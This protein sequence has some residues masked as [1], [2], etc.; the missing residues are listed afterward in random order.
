[1]LVLAVLATNDPLFSG[2]SASH[3]SNWVN[4]NPELGGF[5]PFEKDATVNLDHLARDR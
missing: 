5:N 2:D 1:M 3:F 4:Q